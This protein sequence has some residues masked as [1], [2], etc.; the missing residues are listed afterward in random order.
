MEKIAQLEQELPEIS[1]LPKL[2]AN[3][4]TPESLGQSLFEQKGR[5]AI[6]SDEGGVM[7]ILSGLYSGGNT[8]ADIILKGIDG[9][10]VRTKRKDKEYD[11]NPYL[12]LILA[13]QPQILRNIA[14]K[15]AFNGN[16]V[17]ERFL[18]IVPES[19]LGYRTHNTPPVPDTVTHD[20]HAL[21][22]QLL[23][24]FYTMA[25]E[26]NPSPIVLSLS[27]EASNV[28]KEF[29][30]EVE[31]MLRPN[32]KLHSFL[33]WGG[34]ICGYTLRIAGMLHIA[35]EVKNAEISLSH[36]QKAIHL[37]TFLIDHALVAHG[38]MGCDES[39]ADAKEVWEWMKE[40]GE[41]VLTKR[42]IVIGLKNRPIGKKVTLDASLKYLCK[43]HYL[44]KTINHNTRK[45]TLIYEVNPYALDIPEQE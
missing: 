41:A 30:A 15:R 38:L 45:P 14:S 9:G 16:G 17:Q 20:Y 1:S 21:I 31:T 5:F 13:V 2:F 32:G 18:Y 29:Q 33:G 42:D 19:R 8:N 35:N 4:I 10:H 28:W 40:Q 39:I 7:E 22:A 25:Q 27:P 36:M 3:D 23:Q 34:K 11:L 12:T 26:D 37:A 24:R 6:F 44:C 43:K